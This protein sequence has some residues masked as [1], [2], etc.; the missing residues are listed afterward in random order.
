VGTNAV[1]RKSG[2]SNTGN[3]LN[4]QEKI[5]RWLEK[6][7]FE[8]DPFAATDSERD[9][10]LTEYFVEFPE[11]E[12]MRGLNHRLIF[13]RPGDG[14]TATRLHMQALYR[15]SVVHHHLFAFSYLIPQELATHPPETFVGH[16][17]AILSAAVHHAFVFYA[18]RGFE[19]TPLQD[20]QTAQSIA[21]GFANLFDEYYGVL[22]SWRDDLK[23]V[24]FTHS[25]KQVL[26]N[27]EPVYDDLDP[28]D[29]VGII[30]IEWIQQWFTLLTNSAWEM[31]NESLPSTAIEQWQ[32][33]LQLI[34]RTGIETI[35]LLVDGV[36]IKPFNPI[37][38]I[39]G[40][41]SHLGGKNSVDR[42]LAIIQPLLAAIN[43]PTAALP[44]Y[45]KLFVPLELYL[46]FSNLLPENIDCDIVEWD[47]KRLLQLLRSRLHSASNGAVTSLNQL[48]DKRVKIDLDM[49]LCAAS[50]FSPRYLLHYV[51][52]IFAAQVEGVGSRQTPGKIDDSLLSNIRYIPH[53]QP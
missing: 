23:Q 51:E 45:W 27:L 20:L 46:S 24:L 16:I 8:Y 50:Q 7:G 33:L 43:Q 17:P 34:K 36:D 48:V 37:S 6:F 12:A 5:I 32:Q 52:K 44:I 53:H 25:L 10:R 13:A 26:A 47:R 41:M 11:F 42:M 28:L 31:P 18:L 22:G 30:N 40:N 1:S 19:L 21:T 2:N 15:D 3:Q 14:K 9:H 35:M 39:G 49:Y 29:T 38:T 4:Q